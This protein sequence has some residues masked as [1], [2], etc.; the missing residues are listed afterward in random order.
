MDLSSINQQ[1][2]HFL[3]ENGGALPSE[4]PQTPIKKNTTFTRKNRR[5]CKLLSKPWNH[6]KS[7]R[8]LGENYPCHKQ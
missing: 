6:T 1:I 5:P 7:S 3:T 2:E 4:T 8:V